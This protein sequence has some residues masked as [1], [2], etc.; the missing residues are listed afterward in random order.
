MNEERNGAA[1]WARR[2][3]EQRT[4][5]DRGDVSPAAIDWLERGVI[6]KG[7]VLVP[8]CGTGHE[9]VEFAARGLAVTAVDFA[10]EPLATLRERL[11]RRDLKADLV[12]QDLLTYAPATPFD[13]VYEQTSLC[14]LPPDRWP[15]YVDR[16][17]QWL[18]PGGLLL[19]LFMQTGRAG[20]PPWHVDPVVISRLFRR[21]RWRIVEG[22]GAPLP[23]PGGVAELPTVLAR[24][25]GGWRGTV[26]AT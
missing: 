19:A 8:G 17:A 15:A 12:C 23:H 11:A 9:V 2:Y 24:A 3:R 10:E 4:P 5:W 14:A 18:R 7:R 26:G 21:P 16:L 13:A 1:A 22:P 25:E 20:G 6:G